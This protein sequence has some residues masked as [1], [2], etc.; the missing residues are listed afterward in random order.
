MVYECFLMCMYI[1][2]YVLG[3]VCDPYVYSCV[4]CCTYVDMRL[5]V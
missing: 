1:Q 5:C 3:H 4:R 2:E